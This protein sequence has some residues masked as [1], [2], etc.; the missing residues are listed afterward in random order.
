MNKNSDD[1][2]VG[3]KEL[4]SSK[5]LTKNISALKKQAE[6]EGISLSDLIKGI[7]LTLWV[8]LKLGVSNFKS[9]G[10]SSGSI[11]FDMINQ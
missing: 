4:N 5:I 11:F 8:V 1:K 7:L 10:A 9:I 6:K 3:R 2:E